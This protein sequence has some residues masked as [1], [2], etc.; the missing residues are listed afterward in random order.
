VGR[1]RGGLPR[2]AYYT[3]TSAATVPA[4]GAAPMAKEEELNYLKDQAQA[5]KED[6]ERINSRLRDLE[7]KK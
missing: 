7:S 5:I 3:G 6:L 2:C 4:P 1:G